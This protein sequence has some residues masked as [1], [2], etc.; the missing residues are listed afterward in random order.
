[1]TLNFDAIFQFLREFLS[2][3]Y[4][5]FH[6]GVDYFE[7]EHKTRVKGAVPPKSEISVSGGGGILLLVFH[8]LMAKS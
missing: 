3:A 4:I 8:V 7:I 5:M 2:D 1:M 6:K